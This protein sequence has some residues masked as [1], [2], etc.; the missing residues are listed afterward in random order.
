MLA[1]RVRQ[2]DCLGRSY[3]FLAAKQYFTVIILFLR[4][5]HLPINPLVLLNLD[6]LVL[7]HM[8]ECARVNAL[9]SYVAR[10]TLPH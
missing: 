8:I 5:L 6:R 2:V 4:R 9:A 10:T 1:I 3:I 7:L